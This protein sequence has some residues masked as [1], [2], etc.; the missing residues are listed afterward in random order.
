[1]VNTEIYFILYAP[2]KI[3]GLETG[4][5]I[6]IIYR[7]LDGGGFM[8]RSAFLFSWDRCEL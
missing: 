4:V 7:F 1:M 5:P 3:F 8:G 6:N 2:I